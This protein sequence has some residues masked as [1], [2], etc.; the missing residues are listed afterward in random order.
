M[1]AV[2]ISSYE[3]SAGQGGRGA[4]GG[5]VRSSSSVSSSFLESSDE[6]EVDSGLGSPFYGGERVI[7]G[8]SLFL[9]KGDVRIDRE[10]A[11]PSGGWPRIKGY[12]WA[13]HDVGTFRSDYSTREE[14]QWWAYRSHIARDV[15]DSRLIRLGGESSERASFSW[16]G[17]QPRILLLCGFPWEVVVHRSAKLIVVPFGTPFINL[18]FRTERQGLKWEL[19]VH[20]SAK[21]A[22]VPFG[23]PFIDLVF[24][25]ERQGLK[26]EL[27]VHRLAK[28]TAVPF[29]TSFINL[30]FHTER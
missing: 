19:V 18:V 11:E 10:N 28:L 8:M 3:E 1:S 25:T 21:L 4:V 27:V 26:C 7:N 16:K 15:E 13:S 12:G 2:G 29:G 23:T 9:L 6:R 24:H 5:D 20:H 17:G 14:L 22:A 30:V